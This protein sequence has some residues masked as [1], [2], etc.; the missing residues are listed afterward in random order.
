MQSLPSPMPLTS[1]QP[2][3]FWLSLNSLH[4]P[5]GSLL[6]RQR[7]YQLLPHHPGKFSEKNSAE[8][9]L[10]GLKFSILPLATRTTRWITCLRCLTSG[11]PDKALLK[12]AI[13]VTTLTAQYLTVQ[14]P[15]YYS[16]M[17]RST[18]IFS[19]ILSVRP[20]EEHDS[21]R[22]CST[23]LLGTLLLTIRVPAILDF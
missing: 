5:N 6:L 3:N 19:D 18:M 13:L 7:L 22:G 21:T 1:A 10:P 14:N 17:A 15:C 12:Q 11:V 16:E 20:P 2:R 9:R 23:L 8:I 4:S